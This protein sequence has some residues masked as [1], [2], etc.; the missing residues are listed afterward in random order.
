MARLLLG[1]DSRR[2]LPGAAGRESPGGILARHVPSGGSCLVISSPHTTRGIKGGP[3]ARL[4]HARDY[5]GGTTGD[6]RTGDASGSKA[7]AGIDPR[8]VLAQNRKRIGTRGGRPRSNA[9]QTGTYGR[10]RVPARHDQTPPS[11]RRR[12]TQIVPWIATTG[13]PGIWRPIG[14]RLGVFGL[15]VP[16][17]EQLFLMVHRHLVAR[18]LLLQHVGTSRMTIHQRVIIVR[19]NAPQAMNSWRGSCKR[20][21][22]TAAWRHEQQNGRA[23]AQRQRDRMS[24]DSAGVHP[25]NVTPSARQA[26]TA[27][28][29]TPTAGPSW[30]S[31]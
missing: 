31:G 12:R 13:P 16:S 30:P 9:G 28:R 14:Q 25:G 27:S 23:D 7:K 20:V 17:L 11:R 26:V 1:C 8:D 15:R 6:N 29:R 19:R 5:E 3:M 4:R 22:A 21:R 24:L 2:G 18:R 10:V